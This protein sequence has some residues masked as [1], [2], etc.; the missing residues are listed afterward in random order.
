[1][2]LHLSRGILNVSP[3]RFIIP[4]TCF[5][6]DQRL[7][8]TLD[9]Y[10]LLTLLFY[11]SLFL[12]FSLSLSTG[13]VLRSTRCLSRSITSN[14]TQEQRGSLPTPCRGLQP[15]VLACAPR[16]SIYFSSPTLL[17]SLASTCSPACAF[18]GAFTPIIGADQRAR[19]RFYRPPYGDNVNRV[20][21]L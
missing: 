16:P 6:S 1:M 15:E 3:F 17:A 14:P 12:L 9:Y 19:G 8:S 7:P 2:F 4:S 10:T 21:V 5:R 13:S 20:R 11:F 18:I